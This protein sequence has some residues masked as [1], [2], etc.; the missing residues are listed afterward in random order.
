MTPPGLGRFYVTINSPPSRHG[1]LQNPGC[2]LA[3]VLA[4]AAPAS[5]LR[6]L[7]APC[8]IPQGDEHSFPADLGVDL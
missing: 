3:E 7:D 6:K 1:V 8:A 2:P 5:G 4:H